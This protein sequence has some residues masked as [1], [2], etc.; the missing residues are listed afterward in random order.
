MNK[1]YKDWQQLLLVTFEWEFFIWNVLGHSWH[2]W[3]C[4]HCLFLFSAR[5]YYVQCF[6]SFQRPVL[7]HLPLLPIIPLPLISQPHALTLLV[8]LLTAPFPQALLLT[9]PPPQTPLP[10]PLFP[11]LRPLSATFQPM[12]H[13]PPLIC[14]KSHC[15][16]SIPLNQ[17]MIHLL[18]AVY[19]CFLV[20]VSFELVRWLL[21]FYH[22][23]ACLNICIC[24]TIWLM[25][26]KIILV[27]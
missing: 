21:L 16:S 24:S 6:L 9:A 27:D 19:I 17:H 3:A 20:C 4:L 7:T 22:H 18:L 8:P 2:I 15:S 13:K 11:V 5:C 14:L 1:L 23:M 25:L 10:T 12:W 26:L